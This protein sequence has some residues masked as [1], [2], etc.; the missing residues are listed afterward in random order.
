MIV[1]LDIRHSRFSKL[2]LFCQNPDRMV[3]HIVVVAANI[4]CINNGM[5]C[6]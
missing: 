6:N 5:S 2:N 1:S 3:N 4:I